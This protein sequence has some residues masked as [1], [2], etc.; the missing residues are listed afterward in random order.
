MLG[1]RRCSA[2]AAGELRAGP[3][4]GKMVY[5]AFYEAGA[6]EVR[7]RRAAEWMDAA[8]AGD[9]ALASDAACL[10]AAVHGL[11][12]AGQP[13]LAVGYLER[14][15][16]AATAQ[17]YTVVLGACRRGDVHRSVALRISHVLDVTRT[18]QFG[19]PAPVLP[20]E[21]DAAAHG[22]LIDA[23]ARVGSTFRAGKFHRALL[24]RKPGPP[25]ERWY[26]G[27]VAAYA[28]RG[29]GDLAVKSIRRLQNKGLKESVLIENTVLSALIR[30]KSYDEAEKRFAAMQL[31]GGVDPVSFS[32]M[33]RGH[34]D[35]DRPE[36]CWGL[37]AAMDRRGV[38]PDASIFNTVLG[39]LLRLGRTKDVPTLLEEMAER[40]V[41]GSAITASLLLRYRSHLGDLDG[42]RKVLYDAAAWSTPLKPTHAVIRDYMIALVRLDQLAEAEEVFDQMEARF[43]LVRRSDH[44][45][46]LLRAYRRRAAEDPSCVDRVLTL[47]KRCRDEN[48]VLDISVLEIAGSVTSMALAERDVC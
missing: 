10:R 43:D 35:R 32:I 16:S 34:C 13:E 24:V 25:E 33:A 18:D 48:V 27:V 30:Q 39:A 29:R 17:D 42:V 6:S 31:S 19:E 9:A 23:L 47:L 14:L 15:G 12:R 26:Q 40:K 5:R 8:M 38:R 37:L 2:A 44:A 7:A 28:A 22:A 36:S 3:H 11:S 41:C 45:A 46:V 21:V 20:V 4:A 1:A